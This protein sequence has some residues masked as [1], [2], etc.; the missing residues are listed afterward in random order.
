MLAET[1]SK[2]HKG[3]TGTRPLPDGK[4][5]TDPVAV[6]WLLCATISQPNA[7]CSKHH[8]DVMQH[9]T[10]RPYLPA[11]MNA[12][13]LS[14]KD[15]LRPTTLRQRSRR[16][17]GSAGSLRKVSW[18][19]WAALLRRVCDE[20]RDEK[21]QLRSPELRAPPHHPQGGPPQQ[22]NHDL[23]HVSHLFAQ[24]PHSFFA[25]PCDD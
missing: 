11:L 12:A 22:R 17:L 9:F 8:S 4:D 25:A 15:P 20:R 7:E 14:R 13:P 10:R 21:N 5:P 18:D 16:G 24:V 6:H 3:Q 1:T 2:R 23:A 19:S